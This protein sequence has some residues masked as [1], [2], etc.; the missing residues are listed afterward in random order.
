MASIFMQCEGANPPEGESQQVD[1]VG[2]IVLNSV[3]LSAERAMSE[4]ARAATRTRG[5]TQLN[6]VE[7]EMEQCTASLTMMQNCASG[8][9]YSKVT[10]EFCRAGDDPAAGLEVYWK[11]ILYD[12]M[13][14]NYA[15]GV[16]GEETPIDTFSYNYSKIEMEYFTADNKGKQSKH[17][18]FQWNKELSQMA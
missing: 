13:V 12:A 6:D 1:H 3:S 7:C 14:V 15:L 11:I 9:V 10:F 8:S 17:S 18:D 5:E 4:G 2:W 16:S